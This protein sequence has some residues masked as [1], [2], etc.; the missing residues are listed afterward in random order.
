MELDYLALAIEGPPPEPSKSPKKGIYPNYITEK[1]KPLW[2]MVVKEY[3]D[4][5]NAQT[6][7]GRQWA[8]AILFYKQEALKAK[9]PPFDIKKVSSKGT[10]ARELMLK[11]LRNKVNSGLAKANKHLSG[12]FRRLQRR[13]M[14]EAP[15]EPTLSDVGTQAGRYYVTSK[16]TAKLPATIQ[17]SWILDELKKN[18]KYQLSGKSSA[19]NQIDSVTDILF[20]ASAR[21]IDVYVS[22]FLTKPQVLVILEI[23]SDTADDEEILKKLKK[24]GKNW[25]TNRQ[26]LEATTISL[27]SWIG[28]ELL[29]IMDEAKESKVNLKDRNRLLDWLK[30][31]KYTEV[32]RYVMRLNDGEYKRLMDL[33][34]Q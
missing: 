11:S 17:P 28:D 6:S 2:D 20:D 29:P 23:D 31:Q 18:W 1:G 21:K 8:A 30:L 34:Y 15:T 5:I 3:G 9:I 26:K 12:V 14:I 13:D 32:L 27:G 7:K 33:V 25:V 16:R 24:M 19:Y 22:T 4:T 10:Q